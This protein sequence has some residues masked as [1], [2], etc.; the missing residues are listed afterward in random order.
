MASLTRSVNVG[1]AARSR[2]VLRCSVPRVLRRFAA[3]T[4]GALVIFVVCAYLT[5]C[6]IG[7]LA[8]WLVELARP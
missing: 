1:G 8:T 6:A 5:V 2:Q 3:S 4:P 7:L